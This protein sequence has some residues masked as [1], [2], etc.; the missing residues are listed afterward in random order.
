MLD[1]ALFVSARANF[2]YAQLELA[3]TYCLLAEQSDVFHLL[4]YLK[5]ARR[6]YENVLRF[7]WCADLHC[8]E[9]R[10]ITS[11]AA[12]LKFRLE[13]LEAQCNGSDH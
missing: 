12:R 13:A 1:R 7:M 2:V 8:G 9:L 6:T 10:D 3:T 5:T 11:D 4:N